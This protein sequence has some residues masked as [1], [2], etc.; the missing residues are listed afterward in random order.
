MS[1]FLCQSGQATSDLKW[2]DRPLW[3]DPRAGLAVAGLGGYVPGYVLIAPIAHH[4]SLRAA[5]AATGE[6][7]IG[8]VLEVASYLQDCF[9]PLTFWEHGGRSGTRTRRSAC[10][11]HAHL[12]VTPGSLDLPAPSV[13]TEYPALQQALAAADEVTEGYLLLGWTGRPVFVGADPARPQYYRQQWA[14]LIGRPDEWDYLL[15]EDARITRATIE[16]VLQR[17]AG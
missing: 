2:H 11:E 8:F 16:T 4:V 14:R 9:G 10:V 15:C 5:A 7:F 12:H 17:R 3:L 1:C 6:T 13:A